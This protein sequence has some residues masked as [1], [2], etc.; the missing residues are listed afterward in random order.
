[1]KKYKVI[2]AT[3]Y[4]HKKIVMDK[5]PECEFK[6]DHTYKPKIDIELIRD[7]ILNGITKTDFSAR[8]MIYGNQNTPGIAARFVPA[9]CGL[10]Q[11]PLLGLE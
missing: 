1:M 11:R 3:F 2:D 4:A 8:R 5:H 6:K 7:D 10:S 9:R